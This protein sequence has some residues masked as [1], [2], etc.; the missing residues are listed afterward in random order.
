[1]LFKNSILAAASIVSVAQAQKHYD[2]DPESVPQ[3]QRGT[4]DAGQALK[5]HC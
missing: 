2:I 5:D 3:A 1:M 4:F